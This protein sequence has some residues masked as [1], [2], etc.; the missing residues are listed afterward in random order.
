ML[1]ASKIKNIYLSIGLLVALGAGIF[2]YNTIN[3]AN[4]QVAGGG[5][6]PGNG[7]GNGAAVPLVPGDVYG[8]AWTGQNIVL[9]SDESEGGGGWLN[10]NC[11]PNDCGP[12]GP[13]GDWGTK[14]QLVHNDDYGL[15]MGQGWSS[16]YGWLSFEYDDVQSCWEDNS[17]VV[18]QTPA[19]A[20]LNDAGPWGN[21]IG[22]GKFIAG[23]VDDDGWDG[24]VSFNGVNHD[25]EVNKTTGILRGWAWGGSVTGWVSFTNPECPFCNTGIVLE[26]STSIAFWADDTS[27][28]AGG[29][30][31]A[32]DEAPHLRHAWGARRRTVL[33]HA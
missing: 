14:I 33:A 15:F 23:D 21:V 4:A 17:F 11:K 12:G 2:A 3:E 32:R 20:M 13:V 18:E 22:W 24:C 25:V 6:N 5:I 26:G 27:D 30:M 16:Y 29:A 1:K 8:W 7:G 28:P 19:R 9:G 10:L 31:S